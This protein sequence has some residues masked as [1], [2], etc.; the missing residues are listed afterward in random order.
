MDFNLQEELYAAYADHGDGVLA[1]MTPLY[2]NS[3]SNPDEVMK[4]RQF[5]VPTANI[6]QVDSGC[7]MRAS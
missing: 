4:M 7:V 2:R 6:M 3:N 5:R 1:M